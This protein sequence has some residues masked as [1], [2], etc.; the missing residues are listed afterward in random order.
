MEPHRREKNNLNKGGEW[1]KEE[2]K[3]DN[4]QTTKGPGGGS[5]DSTYSHSNVQEGRRGGQW[6]KSCD[7]IRKR[8]ETFV[9]REH[10]EG[11]T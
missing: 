1:G 8:Q 2:K 10:Y 9:T 5:N 3:E 7:T 4:A 6:R 11:A